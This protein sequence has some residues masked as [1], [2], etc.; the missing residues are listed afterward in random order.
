MHK[1]RVGSFDIGLS[2]AAARAELSCE[3]W[4]VRYV[5]WT[6]V[7][8]MQ[9]VFVVPIESP[10]HCRYNSISH[11]P[12][13]LST[14]V[15]HNVSRCLTYTTVIFKSTRRLGVSCSHEVSPPAPILIVYFP[16]GL[17]KHVFT[18]FICLSPALFEIRLLFAARIISQITTCVA[19]SDKLFSGPV[20]WSFARYQ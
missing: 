17:C 7:L 2:Q 14:L 15:P 4:A 9:G 13:V 6:Q 18:S 16:P 5:L 20:S 10:V 3:L 12:H 8:H 19:T 11:E 1:L